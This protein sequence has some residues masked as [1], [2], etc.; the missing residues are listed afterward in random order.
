MMV[1]VESGPAGIH[2]GGH[3]LGG[4]EETPSSVTARESGWPEEGSSGLG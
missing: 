3:G 1:I 4:M 2:T